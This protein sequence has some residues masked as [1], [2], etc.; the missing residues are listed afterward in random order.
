MFPK[1]H[2]L[3]GLLFALVILYAFP[4][5]G[6][7]GFFIIFLSSFLIDVDHYLTYV[8]KKRDW[9]L[10]NAYNWHCNLNKKFLSLTRAKRNKTYIALC[11]LHSIESLIILYFLGF[12]VSKYFLYVSLGF[13]FHLSLD[14]IG[15]QFYHDRVDKT[16]AIYDFFKFK[17]LKRLEEVN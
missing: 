1:S 9:S 13:A 12:F 4:Q 10:K 14:I 5:T 3:F 11:F 6:I 7:I 2:I 17:K 8:Q 15:D 16:S